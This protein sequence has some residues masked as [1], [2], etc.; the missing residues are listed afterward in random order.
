M[1]DLTNLDSRIWWTLRGLAHPG[2]LAVEWV[3]GRGAR[4]L[5]PMRL[6]LI[7]SA[8]FFLLG[9]SSWL[10]TLMATDIR[11]LLPGDAMPDV[12]MG[13]VQDA[14]LYRTN[15]WAAVIRMSS[16]LVLGL[17]LAAVAPRNGPRLVPSLVLAMHFHT[18]S[19]LLS[20][21][22]ALLLTGIGQFDVDL[23][24]TS[25]WFLLAERLLM[26]VWLVIA[27]RTV[28]GRSWLAA[29]ALATPVWLL[30]WFL[31]AAGFGMAVGMMIE[32]LT[33]T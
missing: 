19:F 28:H 21:L 27:L 7:A 14:V 15:S 6:Y 18:V 1:H 23:L 24:S 31:L 12:N 25:H 13:M 8:L 17:A 11:T 33:M 16:L 32:L 5:P 26:L 20:T 2:R 3:E 22:A 29:I 10:M 30:D 9:G 4:S